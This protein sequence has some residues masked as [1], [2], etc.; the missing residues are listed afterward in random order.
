MLLDTLLT[1]LPLGDGFGAL[2]LFFLLPFLFP[3]E[4]AI[5][6]RSRFTHF[7]LGV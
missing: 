6:V 4:A 3:R 1:L 5:L 7:L 2:V